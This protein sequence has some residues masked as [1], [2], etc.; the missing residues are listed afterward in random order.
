MWPVRR[1][2]GDSHLLPYLPRQST[3][4][5]VRPSGARTVAHYI[6]VI[7]QTPN[8]RKANSGYHH[9]LPLL[10]EGLEIP[11]MSMGGRYHVPSGHR[12]LT[13][14]FIELGKTRGARGISCRG[15]RS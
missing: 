5:R 3:L 12:R 14:R 1:R 7:P 15:H 6:R 13:E 9:R 11:L 2:Y 4:A 8:L 10:C